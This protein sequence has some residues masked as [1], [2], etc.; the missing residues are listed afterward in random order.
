[1]LLVIQI[2]SYW[3]ETLIDAL[4]NDIVSNISWKDPYLMT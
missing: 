1:M 3:L 2:S 4:I